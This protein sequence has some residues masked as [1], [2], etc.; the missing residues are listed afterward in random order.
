MSLKDSWHL[1]GSPTRCYLTRILH[2]KSMLFQQ[3][4]MKCPP[5]RTPPGTQIAHPPRQQRKYTE[6]IKSHSRG[7]MTA[8]KFCSCHFQEMFIFAVVWL[9]SPQLYKDASN[10]Y[11]AVFIPKWYIHH[12]ISHS[13]SSNRCGAHIYKLILFFLGG[14]VEIKMRFET[15]PYKCFFTHQTELSGAFWLW[16][17]KCEFISMLCK[18]CCSAEVVL[19]F[20]QSTTSFSQ[21]ESMN[22]GPRGRR[23]TAFYKQTLVTSH[24]DRI[25]LQHLFPLREAV[26]LTVEIKRMLEQ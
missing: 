16:H 26:S 6:I 23:G 15:K 25:T 5:L 20:L 21:W 24:P 8:Y 19:W 13:G 4:E 7:S 11:T 10:T 12:L 22:R 2:L 3:M 9:Y 14:G 17:L 18:S 1:H